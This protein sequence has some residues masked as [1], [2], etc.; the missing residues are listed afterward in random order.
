M[1]PVYPVSCLPSASNV[2]GEYELLFVCTKLVW[3]STGLCT[4]ALPGGGDRIR[5][6]RTVPVA[7]LN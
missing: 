6:A 1:G 5:Y 2:L 4:Q 7:S 3:H